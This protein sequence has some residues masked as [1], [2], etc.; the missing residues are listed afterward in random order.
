MSNDKHRGAPAGGGDS[1]AV[2]PRLEAYKAQDC[3][4]KTCITAYNAD[5]GGGDSIVLVKTDIFE[6]HAGYSR[7]TSWEQITEFMVSLGAA[8]RAA[9]PES[10]LEKCL[11][12]IHNALKVHAQPI[13]NVDEFMKIV[14]EVLREE[15]K[16]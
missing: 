16:S 10:H 11:L 9:F 13:G 4:H 3:I 7:F 15:I 2:R 5:D 8:R 1:Y 14:A 6:D 12:L